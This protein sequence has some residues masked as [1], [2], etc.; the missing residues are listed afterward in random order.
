MR[1]RGNADLELL[2]SHEGEADE[3][4]QLLYLI[5]VSVRLL[6]PSHACCEEA[7]LRACLQSITSLLS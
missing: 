5:K 2:L 1:R 7:A 3:G 4:Q 6:R